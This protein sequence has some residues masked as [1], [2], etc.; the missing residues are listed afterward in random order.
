[1]KFS[2]FAQAG[3]SVAAAALLLT[4][5]SAGASG[6]GAESSAVMYSSAN[7]T[8]LGVVTEATGALSPALK[9][10]VVTGSSGPLLERI[11]S[12]SAKSAADVFY[13]APKS[14]LEKY[15]DFVEPYRSPEA[16][17][18]PA[19]LVDSKN[20]W[21]ATNTHVVAFMVNTN[22]LDGGAAPRTWAD[23]AKPGLAGK[24]VVAD[25]EQSTTALAALYGAYKVLGKDGFAKLAKNLKVTESSG[26]VYPA[27]A[28]GEYA[29]SIG[30]ESNI[31]PYIA[32]EQAGIEMVYP[33][34]GTSIEYDSIIIVKGAPHP[35][36]ARK[37]VDTI[38]SKKTQEES[39]EQSFRRPSR[40]DID[41]SQFIEFKKLEDLKV[42]D[43]HGEKDEQGRK[44]FLALWKSL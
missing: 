8:T 39:L 38:L 15:A 34:D 3:A 43:I 17:A 31:Y 41:P 37:L 5:C 14:T 21:V 42:V 32:G 35:D 27:V 2:R 10:D 7:E 6:G 28:Q 12:E 30:Y 11:K 40:S 4:G 29:V 22:Q 33:E 16:A 9:V 20:R 36:A 24:V 1:M 19:E 23:L 18:I 25:P 44:D 13:G 26:N